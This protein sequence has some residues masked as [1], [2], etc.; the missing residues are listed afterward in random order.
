[1]RCWWNHFSL[2]IEEG[3]CL[4]TSSVFFDQCGLLESVFFVNFAPWRTKTRE[5]SPFQNSYPDHT[6]YA[7]WIYFLHYLVLSY[8]FR[9]N[10]VILTL[11]DKCII[12]TKLTCHGII[13]N[14]VTSNNC[15]CAILIILLLK[16]FALN[17][18]CLF[19]IQCIK[20]ELILLL[21]I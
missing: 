20:D 1:M 17:Q 8:V 9:E 15:L 13:F 2:L 16:K 4:Y 18:K 11:Y 12:L 10:S 3:N 14:S 21:T 5:I 6:G 19:H 7:D